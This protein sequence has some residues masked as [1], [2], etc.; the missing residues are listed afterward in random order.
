MLVAI[1]ALRAVKRSQAHLQRDQFNTAVKLLGY[2]G[3]RLQ[4]LLAF[5]CMTSKNP[6][7]TKLRLGFHETDVGVERLVHLERLLP[8]VN[9]ILEKP[10]MGRETCEV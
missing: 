5:C 10:M 6:M 8:V 2:L 7:G 4:E 3:C 1:L 9:S